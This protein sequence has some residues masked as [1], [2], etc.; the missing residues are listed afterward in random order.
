[1][2]F[3]NIAMLGGG[4]IGDFYIH[5]LHGQRRTDLV[6]V[7]YSRSESSA[8]KVAERHGIPH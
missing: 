2:K 8:K 6:H 4:F 3:K 5:A 7:V 1:M